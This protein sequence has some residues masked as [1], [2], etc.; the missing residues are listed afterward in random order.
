[1]METLP[2]K[3]HPLLGTL[4]IGR[5]IAAA[6]V[7]CSHAIPHLGRIGPPAVQ[8]FFVLS[9]FVMITAHLKDFGAASAVPRLWWRRARR[10]FPCYWLALLVALPCSAPGSAHGELLRLVSLA[11]VK[12]DF[13]LVYPAWT[14]RFEIAFYLAFGLCLL[15]RIGLVLLAIWVL[16][17]ALH[18]GPASARQF[19]PGWLPADFVSRADI[20]FF[21]GLLAG[22][23]FLRT[24]GWLPPAGGLVLA[25]IAL[26]AG[27][28]A[29]SH[30]DI[31]AGPG[32]LTP[33]FAAGFGALILGLAVLE[34]Q[35]SLR[36]SAWAGR[37]GAISY[38]LYI[39]HAPLLVALARFGPAE[40][41]VVFALCALASFGFDQ[42]AQRLLRK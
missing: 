3:P 8:Y 23:V 2:A 4:E 18:N 19:L 37:L 17:V 10:I 26:L 12:V 28:L 42:P 14:L 31:Y 29:C 20:Y 27:C 21:A 5:F 6:L 38:P 7:V 25:G 22:W 9:G 36:P 1:M 15:P 41:A 24:P 32:L 35:G 11:P 13:E 33:G 16:A 30:G 34:R 39:L 40:L